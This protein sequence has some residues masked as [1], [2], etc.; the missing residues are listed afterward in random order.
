MNARAVM[1]LVAALSLVS[2]QADGPD[3]AIEP[4]TGETLSEEFSDPPVA[5]ENELATKALG[6]GNWREE[7]G[8]RF[9]DGYLTRF[10][11][12]DFCASE[13]PADWVPFQFEGETYYIQ[14]LADPD[15]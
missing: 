13:I 1:L 8:S 9:C 14:P 4:A 7:N 10:E 6:P 3:A 15:S 2:C 5:R 12:D 11:D